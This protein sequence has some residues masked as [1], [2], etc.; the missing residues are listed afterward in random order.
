MQGAIVDRDRNGIEVR[1]QDHAPD[2]R[3]SARIN[4]HRKGALVFRDHREGHMD[5]GVEP[6]WI[7]TEQGARMGYPHR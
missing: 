4:D 1:E 7:I 5:S 2:P 3:Y 6:H